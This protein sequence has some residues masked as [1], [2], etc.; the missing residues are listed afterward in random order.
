MLDRLLEHKDKIL[1]TV[2]VVLC[3][4]LIR[5]FESQLFYDPFLEYFE[6]DFT[7]KTLPRLN[8]LRLFCNLLFRYGL[9]TI[10]SL[11][12][13]YTLFKD[14]EILNF[15]AILYLFFL[16]M[17]FGAFLIIVGYFPDKSWLLFYVRRFIIQPI[18]VL[19]FI[20]AFYYQQQ[21]LKK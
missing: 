12:L 9:N 10:L 3:F 14:K 11:V 2:I 15:S 13:I 19:L 8:T 7:N 1:I 16:V 6:S 5:S 18:F 17:L 4:G 20:P 21:N